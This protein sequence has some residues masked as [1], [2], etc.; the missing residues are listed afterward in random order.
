M[1]DFVRHVGSVVIALI[2][3]TIPGLLVASIAYEWHVFLKVILCAATAA[4]G[5]LTMYLIYERSEE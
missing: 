1:N 5:V 3:V 4:E 2:L